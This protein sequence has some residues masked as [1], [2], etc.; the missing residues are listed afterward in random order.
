[1]SKFTKV[2]IV[3]FIII[4]ALSLGV[5]FGINKLKS[6]VVSS[7][8]SSF[9][10]SESSK[11]TIVDGKIDINAENIKKLDISWLFGEIRIEEYDGQTIRF[12]EEYSGET[13]NDALK[14]RYYVD[15]NELKIA[16]A[17]SGYKNEGNSTKKSLVVYIP[18]QSAL[19]NIE[20]NNVS[21][22]VLI[23]LSS[24]DS[25]E[26]DTVSGECRVD[27]DSLVNLEFDGVSGDLYLT[28]KSGVEEIDFSSVSSSAY[29][30]IPSSSSFK[31]KIDGVSTSMDST[32]KGTL[33][34]KNF[35]V[36]SGRNDYSFSSVSG[37][38]VINEL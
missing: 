7:A 38:I 30:S 9:K 3:F 23:K 14:A 25:I 19:N 22:S 20:I 16:F 11:Y 6:N 13:L 21:S 37:H 10:Y 8:T 1:M 5:A 28:A 17:V 35:I 18:S 26:I 29:I 27:V 12:K 2:L 4:L 31:A 15:N 36:G 33:Q 32:F 24:F 34:G